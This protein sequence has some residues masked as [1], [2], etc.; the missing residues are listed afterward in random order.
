[1]FARV[2]GKRLILQSGARTAEAMT[3]NAKEAQ[4]LLQRPEIGRWLLRQ[5]GIPVTTG[6]SAQPGW[7][8]YKVSLYQEHVLHMER[9]MESPQW[10]LHRLEEP[11]YQQVALSVIEPEVQVVKGLAAR[12]LYAAGID[13][14]EVTIMAA[15]PHRQKVVQVEPEWPQQDKDRF[16]Q[17]AKDWWE[18]RIR[19][20]PQELEKLGADPEFAL[21]KQTGEMALASDFLKVGGKVGCDTTRYREELAMHQ[22]PIAELRPDPS[23][24]P[25]ELFFH[26]QEALQL[27]Y[28]KLGNSKLEWLAGGMPF[29]GYP[30]GG[31]IHFSGMTATFSLRRKL[32]AY[33]ALPLVLIED[34]GCVTRRQRYGFL[35]DFREKSY[36]FEYRTLPS[37]LVHPDIAR[38]VLHLAR[39]IA[40]GHSQLRAAPH[41]QL[42]MI[43]AYYRG[44]KAALVPYVEQ[45]WEELRGLPGYV[46]SRIHLDRYFSILLK[47]DSWASDEDLRKAWSLG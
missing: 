12:S 21:R 34:S 38:G 40:T 13:A 25:D 3:A 1:M 7:R 31:H 22:H 35:G 41:L 23:E 19:Q 8:T 26:I 20:H 39:L 30:I 27:A 6:K 16:M 2:K 47:G 24:D 10:L 18:A 11:E 15:S 29:S 33:L 36:G 44:D 46:L 42:S 9:S 45:I 32:D 37:W 5:S 17:A 14:G 28:K 4:I 43:K